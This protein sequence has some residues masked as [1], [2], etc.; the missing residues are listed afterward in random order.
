M[1][2]LR[3]PVPLTYLPLTY[4]VPTTYLPL[5]YHLPT[6]YLPLTYHLPTTYLPPTYHSLYLACQA[7]NSPSILGVQVTPLGC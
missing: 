5:T 3:T 2:L 7:C 4:H 1:L 6:M